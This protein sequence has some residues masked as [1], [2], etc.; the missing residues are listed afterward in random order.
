MFHAPLS[1]T[2]GLKLEIPDELRLTSAVPDY[3]RL[4]KWGERDPHF[5]LSRTALDQLTRPQP[6]NNFRPPVK[7]KILKM[8]G[9][10]SGIKLISYA[11]LRA[12][13]DGLPDVGREQSVGEQAAE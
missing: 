12:Y 3:L 9:S 13:V 1:G 5:G 4:P 10:K 7:S 2:S 11:S 6:F 8:A